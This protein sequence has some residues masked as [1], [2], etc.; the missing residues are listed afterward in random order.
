MTKLGKQ[1]RRLKAL[2]I[3]D[4]SPPDSLS[5]VVAKQ[6]WRLKALRRVR[7]GSG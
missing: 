3:W 5:K 1:Q 7:G 2:K 6:Q 4:P